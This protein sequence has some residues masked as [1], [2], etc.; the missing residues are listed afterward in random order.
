MFKTV[1]LYREME[2]PQAF[3]TY[4]I[5]QIVPKILKIPGVVRVEVTR[6]FPS[7][8]QPSKQ[9]GNSFFLMSETYFESSEALQNAL[10]TPEGMEAARLIMEAAKNDLEV[11]V[12]KADFF[13]SA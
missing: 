13:H 4:Y 10:S 3:E 5:N 2:N 9:D 11:Y 1:G 8:I 6:I 7:P 12:G